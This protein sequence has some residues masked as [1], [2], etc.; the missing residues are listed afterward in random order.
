MVLLIKIT[1][2]CKYLLQHFAM[3]LIITRRLLLI[4]IIDEVAL[5]LIFAPVCQAAILV[6]VSA[7]A[8]F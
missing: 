4:G 3:S 6:D 5:F 8:T 1:V 7:G 2:L